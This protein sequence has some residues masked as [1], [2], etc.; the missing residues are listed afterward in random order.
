MGPNLDRLLNS[1]WERH[2]IVPNMGKFLGKEFRT[3]RGLMQGDPKSTTIFNFVVDAVV[4]EVLDVV[5]VPQEAQ[6]GLG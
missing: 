6:H 4:W 3:R 1:Y 2:R 5:C